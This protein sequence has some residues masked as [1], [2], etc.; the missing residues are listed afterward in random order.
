M[1]KTHVLTVPTKALRFTPTPMMADTLI[2][3]QGR[4]KV[5]QEAGPSALKA[6]PVTPG[7]ASAAYTEILSGLSE[8]ETVVTGV[9]MGQ[10]P[11]GDAPEANNPFMPG[12]PGRNK[13]K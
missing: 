1:E 3:C 12:P 7:T 10:G 6:I 9:A 11:E 13:K 5:W 8:G 2:D 4:A